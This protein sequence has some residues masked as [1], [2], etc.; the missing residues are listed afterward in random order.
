MRAAM[1]LLSWHC[2]VLAY[3]SIDVVTG[4]I[5]VDLENAKSSTR[6]L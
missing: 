4:G 2:G 3:V 5:L 1:R 6:V